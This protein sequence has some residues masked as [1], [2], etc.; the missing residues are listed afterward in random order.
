M[1]VAEPT[2][3]E[4]GFVAQAHMLLVLF[5]ALFVHRSGQMGGKWVEGPG[6][7]NGERER[8]GGGVYIL[9]WG[10]EGRSRLSMTLSSQGGGVNSVDSH[11]LLLWDRLQS[12]LQGWKHPSKFST[13]V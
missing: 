10:G 12:V 8:R 9:L 5:I 7:K 2:L 13:V 6:W 11:A 1:S 4:C 3:R